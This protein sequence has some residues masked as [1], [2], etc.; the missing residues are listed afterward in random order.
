[1][2][3]QLK[4]N[5]KQRG[6]VL[7]AVLLLT[8]VMIMLA[9]SST[10]VV[11]QGERMVANSHDMSTAFQAANSALMEGETTMLD[12]ITVP[13][14]CTSAPCAVFSGGL[15]DVQDQT[16]SWWSSNATAYPGSLSMANSAPRYI[17]EYYN[18]IP[19]NFSVEAMSNGIGVYY[20]RVSARGT[21]RS[22]DAEVI[23]QSIY[24][25]RYY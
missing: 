16:A 17:I 11:V 7:V 1:M 22:D 24:A 9:V 8:M 21:G 5:N 25:T 4:L 10:S 3:V 6:A 23:M 2:T 18:F 20:Y 19:D 12:T 14:A 15:P 13:S